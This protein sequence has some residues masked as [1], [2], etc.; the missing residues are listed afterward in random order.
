MEEPRMYAK[1]DGDTVRIRIATPD[2]PIADADFVYERARLENFTE[3]TEQLK[4]SGI[5]L[6]ECLNNTSTVGDLTFKLEK[7]TDT[8]LSQP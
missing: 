8:P 2:N 1:V 6:G 3:M 7:P 4:Q 5:H